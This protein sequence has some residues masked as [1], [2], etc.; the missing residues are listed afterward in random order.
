MDDSELPELTPEQKKDIER[1]VAD[2]KLGVAEDLAWHGATFLA[3][4]V[5]LRW[6]TWLVAGIAALAY[7][8]LVTRYYGRDHER[9]W[10][11]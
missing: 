10:R 8:W 3:T 9:A 11:T 6:D 5:W 2:A 1:R 4:L 7:Y